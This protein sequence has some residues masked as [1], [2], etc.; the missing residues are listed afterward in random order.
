MV[1]GKGI[2][3][4]ALHAVC[5][6]SEHIDC[7]HEELGSLILWDLGLALAH[8]PIL[9]CWGNRL[10]NDLCYNVV[11]VQVVVSIGQGQVR[12]C[13]LCD[14]GKFSKIIAPIPGLWSLG[15]F[16]S[17]SFSKPQQ[18]NNLL[19]NGFL[20]NTLDN[21]KVVNSLPVLGWVGLYISAWMAWSSCLPLLCRPHGNLHVPD[22]RWNLCS[23]ILSDSP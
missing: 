13:N 17:S 22:I 12:S 14:S 5:G 11:K 16:P 19:P 10:L 20:W 9:G 15:I 4:S 18:S 2:C 8:F 23:S 3:K 7:R 6:G 21:V 1:S